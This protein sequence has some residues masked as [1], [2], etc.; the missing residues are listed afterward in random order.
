MKFLQDHSDDDECYSP[1]FDTESGSP[2][3]PMSL[4]MRANSPSPKRGRGSLLD[5][6]HQNNA[7]G[8]DAG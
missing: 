5:L 2:Y 1:N 8:A 6:F 7:G 4:N 3:T